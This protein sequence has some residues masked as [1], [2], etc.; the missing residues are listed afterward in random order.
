MP[1]VIPDPRQGVPTLEDIRAARERIAGHV[2]HTPLLESQTLG[3]ELGARLYFKCENLQ[4]AGAF[5]VR[6]ATNAVF[7]LPA[8][9]LAAG[10]VTHSSGN[11]GAAVA[12]AAQLRGVPAVVVMPDNSP[13]AKLAL[14]RRYGA[15]LQLCEPSLAAREAA[16]AD[17][18]ARS[19][20]AFVHPYDDVRVIA[21]QGTVALELLEDLPQLDCVLCPVGG[22][23]L[24]SGIAL[25][26]KALAPAVRVIAVEPAAADDAWRAFHAASAPTLPPA[27]SSMPATLADGLRGMVSA[28]T[29]GV[30]R[31]H[32]DD[33]VT[34]SEAGI[35]RAMR[36]LWSE[37]HVIVEASSAVPYAALLEGGLNVAG[38]RVAIVLTGGNVD[39]DRLPWFAP[40]A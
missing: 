13:A 40:P 5:K 32:V 23:G 21:G 30:L 3:S 17:I 10:V 22:G 14:V 9:A 6:G 29:L 18:V 16:V 35:V 20:A 31:E 34:V 33:V 26:M 37:L 4:E 2:R 1:R 25:A 28:R 24:A 27:P 15:R 7:S 38:Q 8:E 39:L 12:R 36:T 19:G 11:H